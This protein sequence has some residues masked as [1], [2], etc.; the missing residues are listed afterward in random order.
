MKINPLKAGIIGTI[1][2][3]LCCFTPMLVVL[4]ALLGLSSFTGYLDYV[5][6]PALVFFVLLTLYALMKKNKDCCKSNLS[7]NST[8]GNK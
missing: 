3:A 8:E 6:L 1:V 5:L 7:S 4:F 2:L